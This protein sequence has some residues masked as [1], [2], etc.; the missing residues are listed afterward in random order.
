MGKH[1]FKKNN[2]HVKVRPEPI[3]LKHPLCKGKVLDY[4]LMKYPF[5]GSRLAAGGKSA[6]MVA[7]KCGKRI[8]GHFSR[9]NSFPN[10]DFLKSVP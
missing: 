3:P 1:C 10:R 6:V 5:I 9:A 2:I 8:L 7:A 4:V